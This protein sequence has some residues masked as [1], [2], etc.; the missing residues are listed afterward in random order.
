MRNWKLSCY[1]QRLT[2]HSTSFNDD[3]VVMDRNAHEHTL[4]YVTDGVIW[5]VD[6]RFYLSCKCHSSFKTIQYCAPLSC[7]LRD[8][9]SAS[10]VSESRLAIQVDAW[11]WTRGGRNRLMIDIKLYQIDIVY[12]LCVNVCD[13]FVTLRCVFI[14]YVA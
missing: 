12:S 5:R 1:A 11:G 8:Q 4:G 9:V 14:Y 2:A 6:R 10:T 13:G 7:I 3:Q